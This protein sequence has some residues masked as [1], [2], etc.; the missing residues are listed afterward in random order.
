MRILVLSKRQYMNKDLLDDH[1]GRF[2]EI[3]LALSDMGYQVDG[4]CLSYTNRDEGRFWDGKV[5]WESVNAGR[6]RFPGLARYIVKAGQAAGRADVIWACSDSFYGII[7]LW[8]ARKH[9]IPLVFDLYDNFEYYLA[10]RMPV[11]KQLYRLA[12]RRADVVTCIS[13]PLKGHIASS[14][15]RQQ[16]KILENGV[17]DDLFRPM[18]KADCRRALGLPLD[19]VIIGTAGH[20]ARNRGIEVLYGAFQHLESRRQNLHLAVAGPRKTPPPRGERIHDLGNLPFETVPRFFNALDIAVICNRDN[21]FGRYCHPQKAVEIM[22]CNVPLLAAR[23]GTLAQLFRMNPE[24]LYAADDPVSL[25]AAVVQVVDAPAAV[26][27]AVAAWKD[28]ARK[29]DRWIKRLL[30]QL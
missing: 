29:L 28:Q 15:R 7:G 3:P 24:Y 14:C 12:V 9:R 23:V 4:L 2:R 10:A 11:V 18:N 19:A 30:P 16:V 20:L 17:R 22:A 6:G 21:A 25:A 8:A 13:D 5:C 1:Y 27:P 26:Y